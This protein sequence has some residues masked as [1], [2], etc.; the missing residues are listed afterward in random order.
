MALEENKA[1]LARFLSDKRLGGAPVNKIVIAGGGL[2][3]EDS[4][5]CRPN[6]DITALNGFHEEA[7][8]RMI[9][10]CVHCGIPCRRKSRHGF[11]FFILVSNLSCK[12]MQAVV[13]E[14]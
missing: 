9:L 10:H 13:D 11:F 3:R 4:V 8:T 5:K 7:D 2:E 1:D 12:Q 6:I 14:R